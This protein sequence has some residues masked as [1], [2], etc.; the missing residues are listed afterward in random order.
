MR[1]AAPT[2][3]PLQSHAPFS[4]LPLALATRNSMGT[5]ADDARGPRLLNRWPRVLSQQ[6]SGAGSRWGPDPGEGRVT[7]PRGEG[8][9]GGVTLRLG[10][11]R[12]LG[13]QHWGRGSCP[14]RVRPQLGAS[15]R[16]TGPCQGQERGG[17]SPGPAFPGQQHPHLVP[18]MAEL[19]C[20]GVVERTLWEV[21]VLRKGLR[22]WF[23]P[24]FFLYP[25][26]LPLLSQ[27]LQI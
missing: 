18:S 23:L 4:Q 27:N 7:R 15:H 21:E 17:G 20:S 8:P 26:L 12:A 14:P 24:H 25:P 5:W 1:S 10:P 16:V 3:D 9:R 6:G 2:Q 22:I 13:N 11:H 19:M